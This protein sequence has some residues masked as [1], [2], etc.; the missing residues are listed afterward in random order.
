MSGSEERSIVRNLESLIRWLQ[1]V[2]GESSIWLR[3]DVED[4]KKV[5]EQDKLEGAGGVAWGNS[6]G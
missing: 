1:E 5:L 3:L 6:R 4:E 2:L